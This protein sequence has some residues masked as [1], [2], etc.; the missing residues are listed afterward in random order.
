MNCSSKNQLF[1]GQNDSFKIIDFSFVR[2]IANKRLNFTFQIHIVYQKRC[3]ALTPWR[4][5]AW[6]VPLFQ[7]GPNHSSVQCAWIP[8][9]THP[10]TYVRKAMD[11]ATPAGKLSKPRTNLVL[12]VVKNWQMPGIW[13]VRTCSKICQRSSAKTM[14]APFKVWMLNWSRSMKMRSAKKN[15]CNVNFAHSPLL[16]LNCSVIWKLSIHSVLT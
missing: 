14:D 2:P 9:K 12:C 11:F 10:S 13:H 5:E 8:L 4:Q 3:L 6:Q 1:I 15:W 7:T 16:C